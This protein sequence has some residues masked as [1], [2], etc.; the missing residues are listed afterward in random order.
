MP[1]PAGA[2]APIEGNSPTGNNLMA[3]SGDDK[4]LEDKAA[5][6]DVIT[7]SSGLMYKVLQ[8]GDKTG[9]SPGI[10]SFTPTLAYWRLDNGYDVKC[11]CPM[12]WPNLTLTLI[13]RKGRQMFLPLRRLWLHDQYT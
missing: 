2:G 8:S 7:L 3:M 4:Y 9:K 13:G 10:R 1:P 5:E 12:F 6:H 11:R